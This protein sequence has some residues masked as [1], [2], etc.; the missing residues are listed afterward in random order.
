MT[1]PATE[2]LKGVVKHAK[3]TSEVHVRTRKTPRRSSLRVRRI[4]CRSCGGRS[5]IRIW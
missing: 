3:I 4:L 1:A 5:P 2:V